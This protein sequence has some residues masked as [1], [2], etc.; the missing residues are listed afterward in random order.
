MAPK[1][2]AYELYPDN[3]TPLRPAPRDRAW[4]DKSH[5]KYAYRCLPMVI[6]NQYGWEALSPQHIKAT[7]D[8]G[9]GKE[10]IAIETL[11]G[12]GRPLWSSHFGGGVLTCSMPYLFKTPENWNMMVR[13]PANR[14]KNGIVALDG[15]VETD[16]SPS[17]FTMNWQF[18]APCTIEFEVGEPVCLLQP[19]QRGVLET[20]EAEIVPV[21][22]DAEMQREHKEWAEGRSQFLTD[23]SQQDPKAI[24]RGW[25]KDYFRGAQETKI[26]LADFRRRP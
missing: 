13:G 14:P 17:T 15:I 5:Q 10:A 26:D 3:S 16:W 11:G 7:W 21:E 12:S 18:T 23:L 1:L 2:I 4:M 8:G 6:A 9:A 24:Q 20:F 22:Q 19:F 25:E